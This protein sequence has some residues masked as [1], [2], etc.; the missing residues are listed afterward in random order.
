MKS[1]TLLSIAVALSV[2]TLFGAKAVAQNTSGEEQQEVAVR[3]VPVEAS[4]VSAIS[5]SADSILST[6]MTILNDATRSHAQPATVVGV[7][8][9]VSQRQGVNL[10][11]GLEASLSAS[12]SDSASR[13]EPIVPSSS[14]KR[15]GM[16]EVVLRLFG[17]TLVAGLLV[18]VGLLVIGRLGGGQGAT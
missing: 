4:T 6:E 8:E 11:G 15:L 5:R 17:G 16:K 12:V 10:I 14:N 13:L 9:S 2:A 3:S 7:Q 1:R 18:T